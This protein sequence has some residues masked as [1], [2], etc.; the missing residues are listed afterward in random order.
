MNSQ[1]RDNTVDVIAI[2]TDST[3]A[4]ERAKAGP[5]DYFTCFKMWD[6]SLDPGASV[7]VE[8]F[9]P[10]KAT[11]PTAEVGDVILLRGFAVKSRKRQPYLIS[12]ETSGW[13]VW[14]YAE[15]ESAE[16]RKGKK[17][18]FSF[19]GIREEVKGPPVEFGT[20]EKD[21]VQQL[22]EAWEKSK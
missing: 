19:S 11:L 14:R 1:A 3:K 6:A 21:H 17:R 15:Y 8:V 4:P 9:R 22:R 20:E 2:V 16:D 10:W 5:K 12:S 18:A 13:C 7:F